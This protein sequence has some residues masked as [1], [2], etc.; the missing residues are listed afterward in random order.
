MGWILRGAGRGIF[1]AEYAYTTKVTEKCDIYSFGV[2]LLELLTGRRPVQPIESGGDLVTWVKETMN[3]N[4]VTEILDSRMELSDS[5]AVDEMKLVL[6][7]A[8]YCTDT[9][10]I[11]RPSMRKVVWMLSKA[12]R[13][14][15]RDP[16][17]LSPP[18]ESSEGE[19][20]LAE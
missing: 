15:A 1:F 13:K 5:V 3:S 19:E 4:P 14:K 2:V 8:L 12:R 9:D 10:P 20:I 11:S 17:K 18:R 6:K 16:F 7:I